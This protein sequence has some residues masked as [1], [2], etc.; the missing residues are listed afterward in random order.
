MKS[1]NDATRR[2]QWKLI[3]AKRLYQKGY[4][5]QDVINLIR[6]LDWLIVLPGE[7]GK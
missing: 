7:L 2:Y 6:F 3:L 5:R 1:K 4:T